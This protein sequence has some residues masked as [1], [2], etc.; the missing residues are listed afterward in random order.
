[1][2]SFSLFAVLGLAGVVA[3]ALAESLNPFVTNPSFEVPVT[4]CCNFPTGWSSGGPANGNAGNWNPSSDPA[5]LITALNGSQ[6]AYINN[7]TGQDGMNN[8][9]ALDQTISSVVFVPGVTYTLTYAVARRADIPD[10][11]AFRVQINGNY[12]P[13]CLTCYAIT[14]GSTGDIPV[15]QWE[16]FTVSYTAQAA[17]AGTSPTIYLVNDGRVAGPGLAQIEFDLVPEPGALILLGTVVTL[18]GIGTRR[19]SLNS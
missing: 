18:I 12:S 5:A 10:P 8:Y 17:D 13:S 7:Y 6:V 14:S 2:N 16:S 1:M 3:P 11:G 15:G 19:R 9:Y 4:G